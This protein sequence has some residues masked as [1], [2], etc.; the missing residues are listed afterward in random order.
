[1]PPKK[2]DPLFTMFDSTELERDLELLDRVK[3]KFDIKSE[4]QLAEFL[5]INKTTLSEIRS[6]LNP[7]GRKLTALQR[8]RAFNHL[9]YAWAR[10]AL[11]AIFPDD[12]RDDLLKSDNERTKDG[13]VA[14][15]EVLAKPSRARLAR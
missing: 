4:R 6:E 5:D 12:W 3:A 14:D 9:G 8:L 7:K 13:I 10:D 11:M 15:K 2:K 1:M